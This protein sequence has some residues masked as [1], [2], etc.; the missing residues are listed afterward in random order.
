MVSL[1]EAGVST[2]FIDFTERSRIDRHGNMYRLEGSALI[3][4]DRGNTVRTRCL[5]CSLSPRLA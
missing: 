2:L 1:V 5:M 4:D 3:A